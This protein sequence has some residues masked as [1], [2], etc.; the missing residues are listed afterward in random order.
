MEYVELTEKIIGC[1]YRVF[2][3]MGFGF[4]ESVYEKCSLIELRKAGLNAESG[5][6]LKPMPR[7]IHVNDSEAYFTGQVQLVKNNQVNP[8]IPSKIAELLP[9][10]MRDYF[11]YCCAIR[12]R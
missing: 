8:V 10:M 11:R 4:L 2:N 5:E 3:K 12:V 9:R 1:A 7:E 6:S